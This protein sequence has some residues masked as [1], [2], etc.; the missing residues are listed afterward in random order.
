VPSYAKQADDE[1]LLKNAK[2]IKAHAIDRIGELANEIPPH[3]GGRPSEI[4]SG[5]APTS[6]VQSRI[7][8]ARDSGLSKDQL[9]TAMR[10]HNVPRDEFERQVESDNPPTITARA[11]RCGL[12]S[13]SLAGWPRGKNTHAFAHA[14]TYGLRLSRSA[15]SVVW[16]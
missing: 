5:D 10:V 16:Q 13:R 4:T 9:V 3:P 15:A 14:L 2:R 7:Q 1:Q 6:F 12:P 11:R 8:A